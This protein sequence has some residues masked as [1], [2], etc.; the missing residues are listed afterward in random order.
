[1][2]RS[3]LFIFVSISKKHCA[4]IWSFSLKLPL[5]FSRRKIS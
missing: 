2:M 5:I 1:V 3:V 4:D